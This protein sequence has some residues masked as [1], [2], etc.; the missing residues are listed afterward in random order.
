MFRLMRG[1]DITVYLEVCVLLLCNTHCWCITVG[2]PGTSVLVLPTLLRLSELH[3][4]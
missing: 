4:Y 1:Q 3:K 2:T